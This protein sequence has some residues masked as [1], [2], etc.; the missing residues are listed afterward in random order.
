MTKKL[1]LITGVSKGIGQ[2]MALEFIKRGEYTVIGCARNKEV[3]NRLSVNYPDHC[4]NVIDVSQYDAVSSWINN[5]VNKYG[6]PDIIMCNAAILNPK[7][8][9][10]NEPLSYYHKV[11]NVNF[12]GILYINYC[13]LKLIKKQKE[14]KKFIKILNFTSI[15]GIKGFANNSGYN[16]TKHAIDGLTKSIAQEL[17]HNVMACAF[18]PGCIST[19]ML[20]DFMA[21]TQNQTRKAGATHTNKWGEIN[22]DFIV[23]GLNRKEHNGKH[24]FSVDAVRS[25]ADT[26]AI[27]EQYFK[28]YQQFAKL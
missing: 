21:V 20:A 23:H 14:N 27:S 13:L 1:V 5:I 7:N 28:T 19:S 26:L 3:I 18:D 10:I 12:F 22:Y 15:N 2:S 9:F 24:V 11:M 6:I 4:F 16:A 8:A 25:I 17:P